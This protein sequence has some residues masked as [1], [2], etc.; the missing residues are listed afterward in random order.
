MSGQ[1]DI[2]RF[3]EDSMLD[4]LSL[5]PL[6]PSI[7]AEASGIDLSRPL[8]EGDV[9][10]IAAA[11]AEHAVLVFR[12]QKLDAAQLGTLGRRFGVP[13]PHFL[14][15]YKR[16]DF[17][18]VSMVTNLDAEG[19]VSTFGMQRASTWH[20]DE[21]YNETP[22]K[23][24]ILHGLEIPSA[25]GG[26]LFADMRAA[27]DA[28][29]DA[30]KD[31]LRSLTALHRFGS[32][33]ADARRMYEGRLTAEQDKDRRHPAV[34]RHPE[35][36]REILFVNPSHTRGFVGVEQDEATALIEELTAHAIQPDFVY[37]HRWRVGDVVMWDE[38]ATMHRGAADYSANE[39][40]VL[41]RTIVHP[42]H[43]SH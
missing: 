5:V 18:E 21:T 39:R 22:P 36:G 14:E 20:T 41:M 43:A 31:R 40:R 11:L 7:G 30:T 10:W 32:G 34:L 27:F 28:L 9:K 16:S 24:A 33:P 42:A 12:Q 6:G 37:H 17:P 8:A 15:G 23:L 38:Y 1:L 3:R 19:N 26:T 2:C 13:K 4:T 29:P 35:N 25:G